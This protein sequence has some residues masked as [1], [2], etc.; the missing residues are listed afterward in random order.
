MSEINGNGK[1]KVYPDGPGICLPPSIVASRRIRGKTDGRQKQYGRIRGANHFGSSP[2][3]Y[4]PI[5]VQNTLLSACGPSNSQKK[6]PCLVES[7]GLP[8]ITGIVSEGPI[9]PA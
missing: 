5:T 8:Y 4:Y 2:F 1:S 3:A 9:K 6:I 7:P